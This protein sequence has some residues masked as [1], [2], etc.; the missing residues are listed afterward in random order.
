ML[1]CDF[2]HVDCAITLKRIY[3]FFLLEVGNRR[4]HLLGTTTNP[5]GEW[6][7][8]QVRNLL[9]NLD[10]RLTESRFLIRDRADQFT[11]SFDATFANVGIRV[12]KTPPRCPQAN[13][14][15][16]R[17]VRTVRAELT[18]RLLIFG[19][20]TCGARG[21]RAPLITVTGRTAPAN[22]AHHDRATPLRTSATNGSSVDRCLAA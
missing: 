6:T 16:E 8:Q 17:F 19:A 12:V 4:V 20:P 22:F 9:M 21:V 10:D 15:A 13:C 3:V 1:A 7:T 14:F 5:D 2:F 18:D 11:P